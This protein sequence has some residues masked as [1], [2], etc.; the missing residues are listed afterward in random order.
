MAFLY[1]VSGG[2]SALCPLC[3]ANPNIETMSRENVQCNTSCA[4]IIP[5][6]N[7]EGGT[8]Y[9]TCCMNDRKAAAMKT[10]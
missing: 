9:F 10:S 2:G 6:Y 7:D 8:D 5:H 4:W 1:H 3:K